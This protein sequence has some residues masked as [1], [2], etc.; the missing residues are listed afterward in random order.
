MAGSNNLGEACETFFFFPQKDVVVFFLK[1]VSGV[2]YLGFEKFESLG[3][4]GKFKSD[5]KTI[6]TGV[7]WCNS[8]IFGVSHKNQQPVLCRY[9][10]VGWL[11]GCLVT[12]P[13]TAFRRA[14]KR[15]SLPGLQKPPQNKNRFG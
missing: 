1:K 3:G 15:V 8:A 13:L 7:Q 2:L 4:L 5:E 10:S 14:S 11:V 9:E 6:N 12:S